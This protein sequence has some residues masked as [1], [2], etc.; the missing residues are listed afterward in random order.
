MYIYVIDVYMHRIQ[1]KRD[2]TTKSL[3]TLDKI[4][5]AVQRPRYYQE[6]LKQTKN[7]KGTLRSK[8]RSCTTLC[9]FVLRNT[10]ML[11]LSFKTQR[12]API[13]IQS[14]L[15]HTSNILLY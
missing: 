3:I 7:Q 6:V 12:Q 10:T 5:L 9:Q 2:V 8:I 11:K 15:L 14:H 4:Y 13:Y 1:R